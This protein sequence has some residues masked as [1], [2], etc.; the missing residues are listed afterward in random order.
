MA[1]TI[2]TMPLAGSGAIAPDP[3]AVLHNMHYRRTQRGVHQGVF[4]AHRITITGSSWHLILTLL[5]LSFVF[6]CASTD[7]AADSSAPQQASSV[8]RPTSEYQRLDIRGWSVLVNP[9]LDV[10]LRL[11][12]ETLELLDDHLYRITRKIPPVALEHLRTI[13]IW[14]ELDMPKTR[15]MCYHVSKD[16]LIPNGY[17]PDKEG[18]VEVGNARAFLEWTQVQPWMVLHEL[19]HGY[20]DQVFGYDDPGIMAAWQAKVDEGGYREVLHITGSLREHYGLTNQMEYF[21]ETTEAYFGTND[22][23]PFVRG[24]LLKVD[25]AG[26]RLMEDTWF[27]DGPG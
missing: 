21:A 1:F 7:H 10:D 17:N 2:P 8:P 22:F 4:H 14:V 20:H 15:C 9:D 12:D 24:E 26:A 5:L 3:Y 11:K 18:S 6:G 23:H 13:E 27:L 16:W 25:P 19:A